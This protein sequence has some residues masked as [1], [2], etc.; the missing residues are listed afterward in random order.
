MIKFGIEALSMS[1]A[2]ARALLAFA[3]EDETRLALCG[4]GFDEGCVFA[5]DGHAG[6]RFE[7]SDVDDGAVSPWRWNRRLFPRSTVEKALKA[8]EGGVVRLSWSALAP[9][10]IRCAQLQQAE[11]RDGVTYDRAAPSC[12]STALL[13]RLHAVAKA[14]CRERVPGEEFAPE[15][16]PA[17][18]V[19]LG[20]ELD[21]C[22]YQIGGVHWN[23]AVHTAQVSIMPMRGG[24]DAQ[25][26]VAA[27]ER[28][29]EKRRKAEARE[30]SRIDRE[31]AKA[32]RDELKRTRAQQPAA[33]EISTAAE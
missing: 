15:L 12:W 20:S 3:S 22:R 19:A 30:R 4:V 24:G 2:V 21:P 18:L 28:V 1:P 5:T 31:R 27:A 26:M 11:P 23:T 17:A 16:P 8:L 14:C 6:V 9:D 10:S 25:L 7:G 32:A 29:R 33:S 13:V